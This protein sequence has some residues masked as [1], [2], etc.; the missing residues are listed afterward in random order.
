MMFRWS[1]AVG[2]H[3]QQARER[4]KRYF[5]AIGYRCVSDE[6]ELSLRR[7]SFW[8]GLMSA[9]PR[10]ILTGITAK[11]QP[12]GTQTLVDVDFYIFQRG[13]SW[14]ELDAELL[15]EETRQMI[16]YLQEGDA[17]FEKLERLN[18]Q[19]VRHAW[20]ATA[21]SLLWAMGVAMMLGILLSA[22]QLALP[23]PPIVAGAAGGVV[24]GLLLSRL[25]RRRR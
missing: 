9:A 4:L 14:H 18:R 15:V 5:E 22:W 12:W 21:L 1:G 24:A 10:H 8:R 6:P 17:D 25:L 19:A 13:R 20:R 23:L 3:E 16:R 7:G 11:T 2:Y